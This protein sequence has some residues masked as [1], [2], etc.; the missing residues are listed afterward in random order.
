MEALFATLAF[1]GAMTGFAGGALAA[2]HGLPQDLDLGASVASI[3]LAPLV[4][5]LPLGAGF[6]VGRQMAAGKKADE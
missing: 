4:A 5:M 3:I 1:L 2:L 6:A